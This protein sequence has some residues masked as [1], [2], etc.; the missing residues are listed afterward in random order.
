MQRV[1]NK[2]MSLFMMDNS[3]VEMVD[4]RSSDQRMKKV[5]R[6]PKLGYIGC[7]VVNIIIRH[8]RCS[9]VNWLIQLEIDQSIKFFKV[10]L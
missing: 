3:V 4:S 5:H 7:S 1:I 6:L 8:E 9:S 10:N 2:R